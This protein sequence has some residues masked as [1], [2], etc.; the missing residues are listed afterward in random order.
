MAS[1]A[2]R[3]QLHGAQV[4]R[5]DAASHALG[6]D[7]R[8]EKLPALVLLHLALGL[9]APHLLVER[10][11]QLLP[12]GRSGKGGSLVERAAKAPEIEQPLRRAVER[13]AHAVQQVD[14]G[15]RRLA[16]GLDRRLVGQKVAAVNGVVEV[17]VRG[18]AFA[19]Q[20]FG[21]V[22]AALRANRVRALDRN[23]RKQVN[24]AARFRNLDDGCEASQSSANHDDSWCCHGVFLLRDQGPKTRDQRSEI[25]DPFLAPGF[26]A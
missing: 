24:G 1:A 8:R 25:R 6:V 20:V 3:A 18:V 16:H 12:G 15:R 9:V 10:I 17:L 21:C 2:K 5:R 26:R 14:D 22:D 13:H 23:N 19:L 11:E 4:E 7:D